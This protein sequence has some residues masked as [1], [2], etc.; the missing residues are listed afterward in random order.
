MIKH[1]TI[2][3]GTPNAIKRERV[4]VTL[5]A[6]KTI[7]LNGVAYEALGNP[8]AIEMRFDSNLKR[9]GLKATDPERP[10]AFP[11]R[12]RRNS[13]YRWLAAG[14]F[15]THFGI[16]NNGTILFEDVAIDE[17]GVMILDITK[18]TN[19]SRGSR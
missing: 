13:Q 14:A 18:T 12:P 8:I 16:K 19:V 1:W 17:D 5:G 11:I 10:N 6:N 7:S 15:L 9:I 4:R 3:E 2:F